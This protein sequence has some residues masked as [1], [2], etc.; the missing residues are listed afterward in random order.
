L[1]PKHHF[2]IKKLSLDLKTLLSPPFS[3][4]RAGKRGSRPFHCVDNAILSLE[5][6]WNFL[7]EGSKSNAEVRLWKDSFQNNDEFNPY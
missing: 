1:S 3:L 4:H 2:S 6:D 7:L 5:K